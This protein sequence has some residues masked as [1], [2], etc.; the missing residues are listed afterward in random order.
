MSV[1][2][3]FCAFRCFS[4]YV[5]KMEAAQAVAGGGTHDAEPNE[6]SV[7]PGHDPAHLP[8][9]AE[10]GV[11]PAASSC[12]RRT[13]ADEGVDVVGALTVDPEREPL[14]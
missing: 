9:S 11:T 5:G 6:A 4:R 8:L 1:F 3:H 2:D 10:A 13:D 7:D 14:P 12:G